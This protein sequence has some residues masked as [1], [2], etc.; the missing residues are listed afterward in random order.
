MK[1][2]R[3]AILYGGRSGEHEISLRSARSILDAIDRDKYELVLI[4]IDPEGHWHLHSEASFRPLTASPLARV[5]TD[6]DEVF[7]A[8]APAAGWL[9]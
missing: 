2:I 9:P 8:P 7:L 5:Q 3:L 4:G 6:A 1:R